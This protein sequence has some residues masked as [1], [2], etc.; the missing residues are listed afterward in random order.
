[1]KNH[2][3][4]TSNRSFENVAQFKCLG[5]NQNKSNLIQDELTRTRWAGHV[6][7]LGETRNACRGLVGKPERERPLRRPEQWW[8]DNNIYFRGMGWGGMD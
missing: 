8:V 6:A 3:T 1:M 7:W 5:K 2:N 4:K